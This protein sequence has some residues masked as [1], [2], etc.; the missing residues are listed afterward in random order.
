MSQVTLKRAVEHGLKG[1][2][3]A[4]ARGGLPGFHRSNLGDAGA[5]WGSERAAV[6]ARVVTSTWSC[7]DLASATIVSKRAATS[8]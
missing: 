6:Q 2:V 3:Q 7:L 1:I 8:S 5:G 4:A